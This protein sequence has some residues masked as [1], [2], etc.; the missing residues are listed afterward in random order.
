MDFT[1]F[2]IRLRVSN[3]RG[4]KTCFKR[5]LSPE[6]KES[7]RVSKLPISPRTSPPLERPRQIRRR[8]LRASDVAWAYQTPG[9]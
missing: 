8:Y 1:N 6:K 4:F 7:E 9:H 5:T 3:Q 2:R